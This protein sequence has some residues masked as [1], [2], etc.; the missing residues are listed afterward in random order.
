VPQAASPG[1]DTILGHEVPNAAPAA[2]HR[3]RM[4]TL[5]LTDASAAY[6]FPSGSDL[7]P[8]PSVARPLAPPAP[9]AAGAIQRNC[10]DQRERE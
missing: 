7:L 3:V 2:R 4:R 1:K 9:R 5:D 8:P 10:Q 6:V